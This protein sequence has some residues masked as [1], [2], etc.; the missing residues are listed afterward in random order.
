MSQCTGGGG[1]SRRANERRTLRMDRES[2]MTKMFSPT[3]AGAAAAW[4]W[5]KGSL[6]RRTLGEGGVR[7]R[8]GLG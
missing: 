7:G 1:I 3:F 5:I 4:I 8:V 2:S 6:L